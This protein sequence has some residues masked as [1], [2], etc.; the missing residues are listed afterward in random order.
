MFGHSCYYLS[1]MSML[2]EHVYHTIMHLNF[3]VIIEMKMG[4]HM[5]ANV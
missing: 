1:V 4:F 2:L 5:V 3:Y